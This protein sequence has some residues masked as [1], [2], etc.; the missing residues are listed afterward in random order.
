MILRSPYLLDFLNLEEGFQEHHFEEA[1]LKDMQK[2]L[3]ELGTGFTFIDRQKRIKIDGK[4]Y[5][6]DL[7]FYN[8][9]LHRLVCVDL[10][11]TDFKSSH[12]GQ[13]GLYLKWLAEHEHKRDEKPPIGI[14]LCADTKNQE[15]Q[16]QLLELRESGIHIAEYITELPSKEELEMQLRLAIQRSWKLF[17]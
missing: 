11:I 13:M 8:R 3:L 7:L 15:E 5:Y 1:I 4:N 2:F 12:V 6:L 10:K 14:I 9:Q 17:E 16:I